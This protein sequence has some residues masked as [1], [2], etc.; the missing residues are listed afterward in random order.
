M[1]IDKDKTAVTLGLAGLLIFVLLV[2]VGDRSLRV[3]VEVTEGRKSTR[4]VLVATQALMTLLVDAETSQRG[5]LLTGDEAYLWPYRAAASEVG[6][7]VRQLR[8][9][10]A[11]LGHPAASLARLDALVARRLELAAGNIRLRR[12]AGAAYRVDRARLDE[13]KRVMDALR[14]EVGLLEASL[15]AE[16]AR[17][18]RRVRDV[19]R[20]AR[21]AEW[22]MG[23]GGALLIGSAFFMQARE[24]RRRRRAEAGL[25]AAATAAAEARQQAETQRRV[26]TILESTTD[27]FIAL[28]RDWR[29][30]YVNSHAAR[31]LGRAD[32]VG[33][34][35]LEVWPEAADEPFFQTYRRV[36]TD[37]RPEQ[38]EDRYM[39]WERWF[40][41][42]VYPTDEGIAIY[43]QEITER[44]RAELAL[45][46]SERFRRE[47]FDSL[48]LG[49]AL[50]RM[51]G[52]LVEVNPAFAAIL[53]RTV[54]DT[55]GLTY[56]QVTPER[57]AD[58]ER[59]LLASLAATGCYGPYEK[60]YL[61][62]DGREV[63]VRLYGLVVER[64]GE[65][66][67]WSSVEDITD[68]HRARQ[69][70][71]DSQTQLR[72]YAR[73]LDRSVEQERRRLA[74]EVHDQLGQL[75][76][77]MKLRLAGR[78]A[79]EPLRVEL[80]PLLDRSVEVA[81][82]IS[83][84]LRP[85]ML[86]DLGLGAALGQ[87]AEGLL[88]PVG[89]VVRVA[90]ADDHRLPPEQATQ[91]YRIAQ[92]ALTNVLRHAAARRLEITG[93]VAGDAYVL[94]IVDD[95]R[96]FAPGA[97]RAGALG[98]LGMR[99]R[100]ELAGGVCRVESRP[101]GGTRV[102]ASL[103][104]APRQTEDAPGV[105]AGRNNEWKAEEPPCAS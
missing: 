83:A 36:M 99:E 84:D 80:D 21:H 78:P 17:R 15:R 40:E 26:A 24:R 105:P 4:E 57:Y 14:A 29:Y 94:A 87:L 50:C 89:M 77:V 42:H 25:V 52:A 3:V 59:A 95:G 86:D 37:R 62:A 13:G 19:Q 5:Y 49:L 75:L 20:R 73:E 92:E 102:E 43:F 55:L 82:R 96:G 79:G 58:Q 35:F 38:L 8:R 27:G 97:G 2:I 60:T 98:L 7:Q 74:R 45:A 66:Y 9:R 93:H 71:E 1:R 101:G 64:A 90:L 85:P 48:P 28:D 65:P 32:L 67:I 103:P 30:T 69:A 6:R 56:W 12:E 39:G 44:K 68:E 104:L 70:L 100:A 22:L 91:L 31:L 11:G 18:D 61:R 10:L 34:R 54:E 16:I 23:A 53:G 88:A 63:P 33:K 46:E 76:T 81:R 41:N 47:L 72:R 51:D